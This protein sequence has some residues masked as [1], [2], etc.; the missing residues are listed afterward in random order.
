MANE[1]G[2]LRR[3]KGTPEPRILLVIEVALI[4]AVVFTSTSTAADWPGWRG[5]DR[6]GQV[7]PDSLPTSWPK[8]LEK[9]WSV[10]VGAGH[11]SPIV[12]GDRV[13]AFTRVGE[14]EQLQ[15]LNVSTGDSLWKQSY[16]APY[17]VNPVARAHGPG[18]KATPTWSSGRILT[19]GINGVV[20][21][22]KDDTGQRQWQQTF[23]SQFTVRAPLYGAS[24]SPLAD[25]EQW[26]V[27]V[28]G[29]GKGMLA[30][31]D[32]S[33]GRTLW[34]WNE[35]GPGYAS[36]VSLVAAGQRQVV[37]QTEKNLIGL[38]SKEGQ[39]LWRLPYTTPYDQNVV[40][41]VW[42]H[43]LLIVSGT[44]RGV[45]A[46]RLAAAGN[47]VEASEAWHTD[48]VSMYMSSPVVIGDR[49]FGFAEQD[50]G[51]L[52]CLDVKSGK[53]LWHGPGRQGENASLL[54]SGPSLV[55]LTNDAD[56]VVVDARAAAYTERV[57]Y[58]VADSPTWAHPVVSAACLLIK[59][60][61]R[62]TRWNW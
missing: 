47:R 17:S 27:N 11:A 61:D 9:G 44:N 20:T 5:P 29:P 30:A 53:V 19:L 35:D 8:A 15:C 54:A 24:A 52:F 13:Y 6:S 14:S 56:L 16:P 25:G 40:T 34:T 10:D 32:P 4:V 50:S 60:R 39:A 33:S 37:T 38:S 26:I 51:H 28:G 3:P 22:W 2:I 59:D 1:W 7:G 48:E 45:S 57:R 41:P 49:L 58:E 21:S 42:T 31:L 62:L 12:V 46:I 36:P 23:E 55:M 18:P 43:E